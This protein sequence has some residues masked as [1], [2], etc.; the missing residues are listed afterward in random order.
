VLVPLIFLSCSVCGG[1]DEH[2]VP[3]ACPIEFLMIDASALPEGW[4]GGTP[5]VK[6]APVRWGVDKLGITFLSESAPGVTLQDVYRGANYKDT[7]DGYFELMTDWFHVDKGN[8]EWYLPLR[9]RYKNTIADRYRF[10]CATVRHNGIE[11]CQFVGQYG[12]YITRFQTVMSSGMTYDDLEQI[13]RIIDDKMTQ[14]LD[15]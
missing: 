12:L 7:S 6:G 3:P 14:C 10:G 2:V 15:K 1:V 5:R 4:L 11:F 8:T 13:L 9:F